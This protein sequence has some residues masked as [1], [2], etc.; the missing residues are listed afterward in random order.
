LET[1]STAQ[2]AATVWPAVWKRANRSLQS[3]R[4]SD[5]TT[6]SVKKRTHREYKTRQPTDFTG[7]VLNTHKFKIDLYL[8]SHE[9][10]LGYE[11]GS[12]FLIDAADGRPLGPMELRLRTANGYLSTT[13]DPIPMPP[14]HIDELLDVMNR[15]QQS[16]LGKELIHVIDRE[17]DSVDHYRQ[18]H[19]QGH[20]FLVRADDDRYVKLAKKG[21][22]NEYQLRDVVASL[23][24]KF[25]DVLNADGKAEVLTIREGTGRVCVA[26][27]VVI[28]H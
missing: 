3:W 6:S 23:T 2:K 1:P 5:I 28:L 19:A 20:H 13:V 24:H 25:Q 17:A 14:G 16:R 10:D 4:A 18:W 15:M 21:D 26:E 27:T 7:R 8:R 11:L 22:D 9:N 12:A